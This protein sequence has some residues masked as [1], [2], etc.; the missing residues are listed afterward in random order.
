VLVRLCHRW[1]V[2]RIPGIRGKSVIAA[3]DE[4]RRRRMR[5]VRQ[6]EARVFDSMA[7]GHLMSSGAF[8]ATTKILIL[9]GLVAR[10]G[11]QGIGRASSRRSALTG[12][13][14]P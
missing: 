4:D 1:S 12:S 14:V 11:A 9:G 8:L 6:R 3:T 7:I 5:T 13:T 2:D 10:L